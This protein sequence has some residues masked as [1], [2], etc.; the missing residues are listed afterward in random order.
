[1]NLLASFT[2]TIISKILAFAAGLFLVT[3]TTSAIYSYF[4][5]KDLA[6]EFTRGHVGDI[7]DSYFDGL[8]KLMLTGAMATRG[9]LAGEVKQQ[10]HVLDARVIRGQGVIG[11]YG[12]GEG[13]EAASDDL[14]RAALQGKEISRIEETAQGRRLTLARPYLATEKTRGVNCLGCHSVPPGTVL[15]VIRI[16]YDLEP[17]DARIRNSG[18]VGLAIHAALFF[19][20]MALLTLALRRTVAAPINR[21]AALMTRVEQESDLN[22]RIPVDGKDEISRAA[23]AFNTMLER[24]GDIIRQV[25]G[26]TRNLSQVSSHLVKV[27]TQ[28]QAGVDKQLSDTEVLATTLHQLTDSVQEVARNTQEAANAARQ[29]DGEAKEGAKTASSALGAISAMS[30]QLGQA[31]QVIQRLDTDSRDIGRVIGL[32]RDIAEQ[33]NLLALNAAIEAARAGEQ[34]RGFAVVAD[35]VRTLAQRTQSATEEIENIIVKVQGRAQEAVGAIQ[36]A[37]EKTGSS[38]KSVEESAK[39][40]DTISGSVGVITRMNAQIATN[41]M[42]QNSAAESINKKLGDIGAIAREASGH[43]HDTQGAS[44]QLAG[45]ARELESMV[46]QFRV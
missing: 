2:G 17:V 37:E 35:E 38:V 42:G 45:L 14:D 6:E 24:F 43:A 8:N 21:A 30:D 11:Q 36:S 31:V 18:L 39:A 3:L 20:G 1:M 25:S 27:T 7:A 28:T 5:E 44:E 46:N 15:G 33:T 41:S 26:A 32:I 19:I 16:S 23:M 29:A 9:I 10:P 4:S 34:G 22:L 13:T 40:L 12:P